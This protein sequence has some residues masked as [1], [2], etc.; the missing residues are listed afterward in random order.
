MDF[1][2]PQDETG[3]ITDDTRIQAALPT[4]K[5]LS[6][7]GAKV[8]LVSHLG[9][10]KGITPKYTLEPVAIRLETLLGKPVELLNKTVGDEVAEAIKGF[11]DGDVILLENVRFYPEEETNSPGFAQDLAF[12]ADVYVNDA[13]GTA[14]RAHA[15]TEGV[16]HYLPGVAGFLMK[17]G[18]GLS[19]RSAGGTETPVRRDSWRRESKRQNRRHQSPAD[20]GRHADYRRRHGLYLPQ[21]AGA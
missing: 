20:E 4:I 18:T 17:K 7:H 12:L 15:S 19:R 21:S 3:A 9:R 5:Y 8:I 6:E 2:V 13:F 11:K 1:N 16:A 10:P 14:H